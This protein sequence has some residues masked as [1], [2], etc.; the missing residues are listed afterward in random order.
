MLYRSFLDLFRVFPTISV[1]KN[2]FS[3]DWMFTDYIITDIRFQLFRSG[4][5]VLSKAWP[6]IIDRF[7]VLPTNS[8]KI[9]FNVGERFTENILTN[10]RF[11][12]FGKQIGFTD[13]PSCIYDRLLSTYSAFYRNNSNTTRESVNQSVLPK[14]PAMSY[15]Y[16]PSPC[17][18]GK[19]SYKITFNVD[20][21]F[22]S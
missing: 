16:R 9:T 5:S 2:T 3:V 8:V 4:K 19:F 12:L 7:R 21:Q 11:S 14:I 20:E 6:S 17:L 18:T 22:S 13:S 10:A 1:K 15:L